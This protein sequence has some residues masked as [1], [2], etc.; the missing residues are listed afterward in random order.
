MGFS[1]VGLRPDTLGISLSD[2]HQAR[3]VLLLL[4]TRYKGIEDTI[5]AFDAGKVFWTV[6]ALANKSA[7]P[8]SVAALLQKDAPTR[9]RCSDEFRGRLTRYFMSLKRGSDDMFDRLGVR[10]RSAADMASVVD[11]IVDALDFGGFVPIGTYTS[12][13]TELVDA[14]GNKLKAFSSFYFHCV[15]F[16]DPTWATNFQCRISLHLSKTSKLLKREGLDHQP[17]DYE[18]GAF[19]DF[20]YDPHFKSPVDTT[21]GIDVNEFSEWVAMKRDAYV[22]KHR[23]DSDMPSGT[24][25]KA[26]NR[27]K[28]T[29]GRFYSEMIT[30]VALQ[31]DALD[32]LGMYLYLTASLR[33]AK[34]KEDPVALPAIIP[35]TLDRTS[36]RVSSAPDGSKLEEDIK[37]YLDLLAK[38][39]ATAVKQL[40][41]RSNALVYRMSMF[42]DVYLSY[43]AHVREVIEQLEL[44]S[45][46]PT[47]SEV[48]LHKIVDAYY[49]LFGVLSFMFPALSSMVSSVAKK[50]YAIGRGSL[51]VA[52]MEPAP[53]EAWSEVI[54]T[55]VPDSPGVVLGSPL[56]LLWARFAGVSAT[57]LKTLR[58]R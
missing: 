28:A 46:D 33:N 4:S 49:S 37:A 22:R 5:A 44:F 55:P 14:Q 48:S 29:V 58:G 52:F 43:Q 36:P 7:S 25:D 16:R 50:A 23:P 10:H 8:E 30:A 26:L 57:V 32:V 24:L 2:E 1:S 6:P 9:Q 21:L 3:E 18:L 17:V 11:G 40:V 31:N 42:T 15:L 34:F 53:A 19:Y 56:K 35:G 12:T 20:T 13:D 41:D 47:L 54:R 27:F 38:A 51:H 39:D 45:E